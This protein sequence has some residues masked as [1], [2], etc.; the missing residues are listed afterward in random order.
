MMNSYTPTQKGNRIQMDLDEFRH[1]IVEKIKLL[2]CLCSD[3]HLFSCEERQSLNEKLS[4]ICEELVL[5]AFDPVPT[6]K[7][8]VGRYTR[9]IQ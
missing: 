9:L 2:D 1:A 5:S 7:R 8:F 6:E 4:L 3:A